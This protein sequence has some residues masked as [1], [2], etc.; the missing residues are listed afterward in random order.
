MSDHAPVAT[1]GPRLVVALLATVVVALHGASL[2]HYGY[3]RDELYYLACAQHLAL[4]YVDHPPFSIAVL[5]VVR[6]TLGTSLPALRLVPMLASIATLVLTGEIVRAMRGG[7][8][9]TAVACTAEALAPIFLAFGHFY[10]MNSLDSVFWALS[11]WLFLRINDEPSTGRWLTLGLVLGLGLENKASIL[12]L[13]AALAVALLV[14]RRD[15]LKTRGPWLAAAVAALVLAPNVAW[16]TAHGWPTVEF[17]KNAMEGKYKEHTLASFLGGVAD[18]MSPSSLPLFM[19]GA[20]APFAMRTLRPWRPLA[21]IPLVTFLI[22]AASKAAKA[23]YLAA[24]FP[25]AFAVAGV[26][27]EIWLRAWPRGRWALLVPVVGRAALSIPFVVPILSIDRFLA[28]QAALGAKPD[29]SEKKDMGPLPQLYADMFGWNELVD[30]VAVAAATLT[31]EERAHAGVLSRSG[32]GARQPSSSSARRAR[33]L[34]V[35]RAT[36]TSISGD[37]AK[38]TVA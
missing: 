12:W 29:S 5:A 6:A 14:F 31:P 18:I 33:S 8:F 35:S 36:T 19:V 1:R 16:E 20:L 23:E 27:L 4:G 37:H 32:Y 17:A 11:A 2:T 26:A 3:F 38:R 22:L 7:V 15:L 9:A 10:S 30:A 21:C 24:S 13:G 34:T 28:Y 25:V